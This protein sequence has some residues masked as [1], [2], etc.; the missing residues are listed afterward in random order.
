MLKSNTVTIW[1]FSNIYKSEIK[2]KKIWGWVEDED[3]IIW[4]ATGQ[5]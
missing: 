1:I 2:I 3:I 4:K 5:I